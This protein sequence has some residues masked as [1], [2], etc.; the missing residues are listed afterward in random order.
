MKSQEIISSLKQVGAAKLSA[1]QEAVSAVESEIKTLEELDAAIA[2]EIREAS[3]KSFD[4]GLA[5]AGQANGTDKLYS[6]A[7]MN[8]F[9]EEEKAKAAIEI[10]ALN[11]KIAALESQP[12]VDVQAEIAA[13][14]KKQ[15]AEF[16]AKLHAQ[17]AIENESESALLKMFDEEEAGPTEPIY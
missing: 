14:L 13:A 5:Q 7:E 4:E 3:E 9:L 12:Q 10:S 15:K 8:K 6:D 17:Q 16:R 11:E 2:A 1:A